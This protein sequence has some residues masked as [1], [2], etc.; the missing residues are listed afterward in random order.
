MVV[1]NDPP[2]L[3]LLWVSKDNCL[4]TEEIFNSRADNFISNTAGFF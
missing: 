3:K 1:K 2:S 4:G